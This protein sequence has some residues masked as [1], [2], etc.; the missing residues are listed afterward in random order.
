MAAV[1][2]SVAVGGVVVL[3]AAWAVA[4][5][6]VAVVAALVVVAPDAVAVVGSNAAA[7]WLH[8]CD[9]GLGSRCCPRGAVV[10]PCWPPSVVVVARVR[11]SR[12]WRVAC[13]VDK[14]TGLFNGNTNASSCLCRKEEYYQSTSTGSC[15]ACP[16]GADC[17]LQD[18]VTLPQLVAVNGFW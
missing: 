8:V 11:C 14:S 5:A 2:R 6:A 7:L 16:N 4:V 9:F 13:S 12:W 18:G 15:Q 3:A 10:A 17:S 1:H